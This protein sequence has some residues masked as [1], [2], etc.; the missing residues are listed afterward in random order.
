MAANEDWLA[1]V[2]DTAELRRTSKRLRDQNRITTTRSDIYWAHEFTLLARERVPN[3]AREWQTREMA[4]DWI[5]AQRQLSDHRRDMFRLETAYNNGTPLSPDDQARAEGICMASDAR[6]TPLPTPDT[7]RL[8]TLAYLVALQAD[9]LHDAITTA[10]RATDVMTPIL[11]AHHAVALAADDM[12]DHRQ[13][14]WVREFQDTVFCALPQRP[15]QEPAPPPTSAVTLG[16]PVWRDP[17][18]L[19]KTGDVNQDLIEQWRPP[20][21]VIDVYDRHTQRFRL[22]GIKKEEPIAWL[23]RLYFRYQLRE[24]RWHQQGRPSANFNWANHPVTDAAFL[25][26]LGLDPPPATV[27]A[28]IDG[29]TDNSAFGWGMHYQIPAAQPM[30]P[31][32]VPAQDT[33]NIT[34]NTTSADPTHNGGNYQFYE[35]L[36]IAGSV[37]YLYKYARRMYDRWNAAGL[38]L[39]QKAELRNKLATVVHLARGESSFFLMQDAAEEALMMQVGP[40]GMTRQRF[41][42]LFYDD[43]NGQPLFSFDSAYYRQNLGYTGTLR[44]VMSRVTGPLSG[45]YNL[46]GAL[47]SWFIPERDPV[48][49]ERRGKR[50]LIDFG[51]RFLTSAV[52][53]YL[54]ENYYQYMVGSLYTG[55]ISSALGPERFMLAPAIITAS[56]WFY[57]MAAQIVRPPDYGWLGL[58]S[59]VAPILAGT[60]LAAWFHYNGPQTILS[61]RTFVADADDARRYYPAAP[62]RPT[63]PILVQAPAGMDLAPHVREAAQRAEKLRK[64]FERLGLFDPTAFPGEEGTYTHRWH[65]LTCAAELVKMADAPATRA[66]IEERIVAIARDGTSNAILTRLLAAS[67]QGKKREEKLRAL[68]AE[69]EPPRAQPVAEGRIERAMAYLNRA[70]EWITGS[71]ARMTLAAEER[72]AIFSEVHPPDVYDKLLQCSAHVHLHRPITGNATMT[73]LQ[74]SDSVIEWKHVGLYAG[75]EGINGKALN[76]LRVAAELP[77][78]TALVTE[79]LFVPLPP[80]HISPSPLVNPIPPVVKTPAPPSYPVKVLNALGS[81]GKVYMQLKGVN[82]GDYWKL[83]IRPGP[84][85]VLYSSLNRLGYVIPIL[86]G[87]QMA[88]EEGAVWWPLTPLSVLANHITGTSTWLE[89]TLV[90]S[91]VRMGYMSMFLGMLVGDLNHVNT[92]FTAGLAAAS[93]VA[94]EYYLD[95]V[96]GGDPVSLALQWEILRHTK[97]ARHFAWSSQLQLSLAVGRMWAEMTITGLGA[98]LFSTPLLRFTVLSQWWYTTAVTAGTTLLE[99][100]WP[101]EWPQ[102]VWLAKSVTWAAFLGLY[103]MAYL[104]AKYLPESWQMRRHFRD[105]FPESMIIPGINQLL[106]IARS[107]L[108][109]TVAG[110]ASTGARQPAVG[111]ADVPRPTDPS[112][113]FQRAVR[114]A[115]ERLAIMGPLLGDKRKGSTAVES[116]RAAKEWTLTVAYNGDGDDE[117]TTTM[118]PPLGPADHDMAEA[119]EQATLLAAPPGLPVSDGMDDNA[120][121]E[122]L[123]HVP[124]AVAPPAVEMQRGRVFFPPD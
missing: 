102:P 55:L 53:T 56:T 22:R 16:W 77:N 69:A 41:D 74:L 124:V 44:P 52:V 27:G 48:T 58:R 80:S 85:F 47:R 29:K 64:E 101:A 78:T 2:Q 122:L 28:A 71:P 118:I 23:Q 24:W 96:A 98:L 15:A 114:W 70:T 87:I 35:R 115:I 84:G 25:A 9:P 79:K 11:V 109:Q 42:Q 57:K 68:V 86:P 95:Q 104:A 113:F 20:L 82:D 120:L 32:A 119:R 6:R 63:P 107:Q 121:D 37:T 7:A 116:N 50:R 21:D 92:Y 97:H 5:D 36:A 105:L 88:D 99:Q 8:K 117:T 110:V 34:P 67:S 89:D 43:D 26:A 106:E 94:I 31:Y 1:A 123:F 14:G 60:G 46:S 49:G 19:K 93:S 83:F 112:I 4:R 100:F 73:P 76:W 33:A 10:L 45:Y 17:I 13:R 38:P 40:H 3:Y 108:F 66:L 61:Y 65:A 51:A 54:V 39:A 30:D 111:R 59:T 18:K 91:D 75:H 103:A 72:D 12:A 81:A 62:P 90:A